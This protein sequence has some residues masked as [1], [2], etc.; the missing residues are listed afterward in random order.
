MKII[1]VT[2]GYPPSIGGVQ[3]CV[4]QLSEGLAKLGH[5]VTVFT[6]SGG[7][8]NKN[9]ESGKNPAVHYLN[10]WQFAHTPITLSL[11]F[12][13]CSI[14]RDSIIH[15]HISQAFV[16]E[17]VYLI[18][19]IRKIP[20]V[21]HFHLDIGPSG[22]L[23]FLL[24]IY[25]RLFLMPVLKSAQ[26]V[27]VLTR[28][29]KSLIRRRYHISRRVVIIPNGVDKE[30]FFPTKKSTFQD[31]FNLLFV[32]RLSIQK[33]VDVLVASVPLIKNKITLH[34]V[35][36]GE[37]MSQI[38]K[39]VTD[40]GLNNVIL[41]GSKTGK[42][43]LDFYRRADIFVLASRQEGLP[44]VLLEAMAGG[45]PIIASDVVGNHEFVGN[46]GLLVNPP[47]PENFAA[48]IDRLIEDKDLAH[49]LSCRGRKRA[50]Q[51]SWSKIVTR[52]EKMYAGVPSENN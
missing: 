36:E 33:R 14:P 45:V 52:F 39:M 23:G 24:P 16:P 15:V 17:I 12:K 13:L 7:T 10:S 46:T 29:Y 27:V 38:N 20:Y 8:K 6:C 32:G 4:K 19:K 47:T 2:P 25:K 48:Q 1:Q 18:S 3:N 11:F 9:S 41:H 37:L 21:A 43:L 5:E 26:K 40:R 28:Q 44:L 51:Y 49:E 30:F 34:I 31:N 50:L 35:G 22:K 42:R